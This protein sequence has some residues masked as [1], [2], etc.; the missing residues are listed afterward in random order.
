MS[1]ANITDFLHLV[2]CDASWRDGHAGL[3][4]TGVLG[5]HARYERAPTSVMAEMQAMLWA[6]EMADGVLLTASFATD[7]TSVARYWQ[8]GSVE[9]GSK[10]P[11]ARGRSAIKKQIRAH[12][13]WNIVEVT[14]RVTVDADRLAWDARLTGEEACEEAA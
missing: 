6:M 13:G 7:C 10:R 9:S 8:G 14:N 11:E 4:V 2:I 5:T 12:P 3:G 1:L